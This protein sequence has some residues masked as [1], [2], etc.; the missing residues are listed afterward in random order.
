M[1]RQVSWQPRFENA[2]VGV[3]LL[4]ADVDVSGAAASYD[5]PTGADDVH[6]LRNQGMARD[7]GFSGGQ[8]V[9]CRTVGE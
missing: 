9:K 4:C 2:T 7:E 6:F 5:S 1:Y 3:G 8:M